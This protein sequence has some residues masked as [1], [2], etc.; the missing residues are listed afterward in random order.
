V[1]ASGLVYTPSV[2]ELNAVMPLVYLGYAGSLLDNVF[3]QYVEER[4]GLTPGR[5]LLQAGGNMVDFVGP[6]TLGRCQSVDLKP[7]TRVRIARDGV[8]DFLGI[9]KRRHDSGQA[10]QVVWEAWDYRWLLSKI[11][12]LGCLVYNKTDD[13]V[14]LCTSYIHRVNPE[15]YRNCIVANVP[16]YG[17]APVFNWQ[18]EACDREQAIELQDAK[19]EPTGYVRAWTPRLHLMYLCCLANLAKNSVDG[20]NIDAWRSIAKSDNLKWG[21]DSLNFVAG[22]D[23]DHVMPDTSFR[24]QKIL[25]AIGETLKHSNT[26][27]L[28][29]TYDGDQSRVGFYIK[30]G[31]AGASGAAG[32]AV[33]SARDLP[34]QRGGDAND[35][36]TIHDFDL[37]EDS[38]ETAEAVVAL[39]APNHIESRV[40]YTKDPADCLVPAWESET[41]ANGEAYAARKCLWGADQGQPIGDY[42]IYPETINDY[43]GTWLTA[44]GDGGRPLAVPASPS[45][46]DLM[47]QCFPRFMRAFKLDSEQLVAAGILAASDNRFAATAQFAVLSVPRKPLPHQ[48]S[49][50][51]DASGEKTKERWPIRVEVTDLQAGGASPKWHDVTAQSGLEVKDDSYIYLSGLTDENSAAT[52]L[53]YTGTMFDPWNMALKGIRLNLAVPTDHRVMGYAEQTGD[54]ASEIADELEGPLEDSIDSPGAWR[55]EDR[56]KSYPVAS[57]QKILANGTTET[58][59][60]SGI[61][62]PLLDETAD[63]LAHAQQR[64]S[65]SRRRRQASS[66][67]LIGIRPEYHAGDFIGK[68][69][70]SGGGAGDRDYDLNAPL[71]IL[72]RDYMHQETIAGN[73][74]EHGHASTVARASTALP[75]P[76][77]ARGGEPGPSTSMAQTPY[78]HTPSPT[79]S[80]GHATL[81][82]GSTAPATAPVAAYDYVPEEGA[83]D[84]WERD[85]AT[86][87]SSQRQGLS[88]PNGEARMGPGQSAN[89]ATSVAQ[90]LPERHSNVE[91][92]DSAARAEAKR[93]LASNKPIGP[94]ERKDLERRA[95]APTMG[96][97]AGKHINRGIGKTDEPPPKDLQDADIEGRIRR[98]MQKEREGAEE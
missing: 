3:V 91:A 55:F 34:L 24:G 68:I 4:T 52:D 7:Y 28:K 50:I 29:M 66:W 19:V 53:L 22:G 98:Q 70:C 56:V 60:E 16:G 77:P 51:L 88:V 75:L 62:G 10:D 14:K 93:Q 73:I 81:R 54:V 74:P 71:D 76:T 96:W 44:D 65:F 27:G 84:A 90:T 47:R 20:N 39:G 6:V 2:A 31:A 89:P 23:M 79:E 15:G 82:G 80:P 42:C 43:T 57:P 46:I 83:H 67:R 40:S 26:Y 1:P 32:G 61:G 33:P 69:K 72:T 13:T 36:N 64:L 30:A 85:S 5:A 78:D 45:A 49:Y 94:E 35:I 21:A 92:S 48:L 41:D 97:K 25:G 17:A 86:D 87:M 18:A 11:A 59:G 37:D 38:A 12:I 95:K 8:T 9:L 58:S 63:A